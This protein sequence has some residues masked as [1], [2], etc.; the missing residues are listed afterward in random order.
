MAATIASAVGIAAI[1][2]RPVRPF[3]SAVISCR[4]ARLSLTMRRA[5]SS[6]RWPSGVKPMKR[7]PRWTSSTPSVSSSCLMPA[8][9]VGWVTPQEFGRAPEMLL[10][11]QRHQIFELVQHVGG[12]TSV[13]SGRLETTIENFYRRIGSWGLF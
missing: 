11:R 6:V 5:Q 13:F 10:A 9:K 8:D 7:E 1:F 12:K 3:L 2:S 4:M